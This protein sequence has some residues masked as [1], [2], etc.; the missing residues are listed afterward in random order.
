M[1]SQEHAQ[2]CAVFLHVAQIVPLKLGKGQLSPGE[3]A[4]PEGLFVPFI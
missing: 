4:Q 1:V 2:L 3:P